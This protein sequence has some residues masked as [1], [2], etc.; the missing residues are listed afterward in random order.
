MPIL[1]QKDTNKE[2]GPGPKQSLNINIQEDMYL[3]CQRGLHCACDEMCRENSVQDKPRD[4]IQGTPR[5]TFLS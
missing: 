1:K 5:R 4:P 2:R 3:L